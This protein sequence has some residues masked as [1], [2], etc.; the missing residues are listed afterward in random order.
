MS[1]QQTSEIITEGK[2]VSP[3]ILSIRSKIHTDN[4]GSNTPDSWLGT[5][6]RRICSY[7]LKFPCWIAHF[8]F[9]LMAA[10]IRLIKLLGYWCQ[11][12]VRPCCLFHSFI[13]I[14]ILT[15]LKLISHILTAAKYN[16][17]LRIL[18]ILEK[19]EK[20]KENSKGPIYLVKYWQELGITKKRR[21]MKSSFEVKD[22]DLRIAKLRPSLKNLQ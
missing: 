21:R 11:I 3:R 9:P 14:Y 22:E 20:K 18:L 1:E 5:D 8:H 19:K 6:Y 13:N 17:T 15:V 12:F 7:C 2:R 10:G 4:T 16:H